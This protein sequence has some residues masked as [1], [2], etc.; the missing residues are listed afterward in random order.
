MGQHTKEFGM[1]ASEPTGHIPKFVPAVVADT[2]YEYTEYL[3][4]YAPTNSLIVELEVIETSY[5]RLSAP[6]S[7][8]FIRFLSV[9]APIAFS[10]F[11]IYHAIYFC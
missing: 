11:T 4:S 9:Y 8:N 7:V 5:C 1:L 10:A 3:L 6:L 2:L